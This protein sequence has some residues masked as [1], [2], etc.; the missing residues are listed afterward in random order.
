[1]DT[2]N[3]KKAVG[4]VI[5]VVTRWWSTYF[6]CERLI[7]LQPALAAVALDNRL[8]ESILL[9]ET[10][11]MTIREV[12]KLLKQ[13]KDAQEL[14]E[15]DKYVTLSLLPIAIKAIR[16]ALIR[17]VGAGEGEGAAQNR[18]RNLAKRLLFDFR[19]RWK[20]DNASQYLVWDVITRGCGIQQVGLHR[21]AAFASVLDPRIKLLKAYSKEDR[22]KIWAGLHKK[23]MEHCMLPGGVE[24]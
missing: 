10:D 24:L 1:M 16:A 2:Y 12:H 15:G 22:I 14:L 21:L 11:W 3:G 13:C 6:M 4:V 23:V 7:H 19:E 9:N 20:P 8:P 18:V 5:D 17:I